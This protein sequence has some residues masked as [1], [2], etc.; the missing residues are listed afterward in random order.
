MGFC[1]SFG[2]YSGDIMNSRMASELASMENIKVDQ[3]IVTDDIASSPKGKEKNRRGIAGIFYVY[4]IAGAYAEEGESFE[5][6]KR[7]AK[8]ANNNVRTMGVGLSPCI[9]P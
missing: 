5:E 6:V 9:H 7:V 3:I 1:I 8:K 2:N 4:K